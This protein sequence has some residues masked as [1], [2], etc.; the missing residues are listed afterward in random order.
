MGRALNATA[1]SVQSC[2][3]GREECDV[4]PSYVQLENGGR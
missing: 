1:A 2:G 4:C 3:L